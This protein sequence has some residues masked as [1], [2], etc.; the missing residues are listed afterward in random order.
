MAVGLV[1]IMVLFSIL[2]QIDAKS[3]ETETLG[4]SA[5]SGLAPRAIPVKPVSTIISASGFDGHV[6]F[7]LH[8]GLNVRQVAGRL[9][10]AQKG[11][12][13]AVNRIL[14]RSSVLAVR[15]LFSRSKD[16]LRAER[17]AAQ[18]ESRQ[19]LADLSLYYRLEVSNSDE[20]EQIIDRLN[21]DPDVEIAYYQPAPE[22]AEAPADPAE[23]PDFESDQD[24]LKPAPDGVD[25]YFAWT[26]IGGR[27]QD[28]KIV[29]IEGAW[30]TTHEDLTKSVGGLLGGTMINN[31]NW[32]NHGTAVIGEMIA[33][34]NGF[35][36]T[37][38]AYEA[39][40]GMVSIAS[41]SAAEAISLATDSL[42]PGDAILIELHA[43]GPRYDFE[44]RDDQLGY[45]CMEYWQATFDAIQISSAKG[46]IVCEAAGN[47]AED[48]DDVIYENRFDTTY[49]NSH[50]IIC[51]AGAPPSGTYGPDRSRLS[52]SNYGERVNLQGYG[53]GV[54]TT[55]YGSLY[56]SGGED[57]YYTS[58]F[59]GT[60]SASPIVTGAV[61]CLSGYY[62]AMF[63]AVITPDAARDVLVATGSS[64]YPDGSEH[65]GPRP[66]LYGAITAVVAPAPIQISPSYWDTA[67]TQG[68]EATKILTI[69]NDLVGTAWE[70]EAS[71]QEPV[72]FR[73]PDDSWLSVSPLSG[74]VPGDGGTFDLTI[75]VDAALLDPVDGLAKGN[76]IVQAPG[77]SPDYQLVIPVFVDT[78]C[79]DDETYSVADSDEPFGPV[80]DWI[81]AA[82]LGSAI[83]LVDYYNSH[84]PSAALDDGT[85]GPIPIGF[86]FD[87]YGTI[88]DELYIG[89]NGAVSFTETE[90]NSNGYF[91][92]ISIPGAFIDDGIFAF[93][94]DLAID[95]AFGHGDIF[96]YQS[97]TN[98][99][100]VIE[101][102]Q[103]GNFN[104]DLDTLTTFEIILTADGLICI[105][106][107]DVGT[108][109]LEQTATVGLQQTGCRYE[110]Y[111][112]G[113]VPADNTPHSSLTVQF[114]S[115]GCD[116]AVWGDVNGDAAI[117]PIDVVFMVN[118]VYLTSDMRV[119]PPNC[120]YEAGD[121]N[122]DGGVNPVDVVHFVNYVYMTITPFPCTDPCLP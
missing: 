2:S 122:C 24:Y 44:S 121:V 102:Y 20:A 25:A 73:S 12:L 34:N 104:D 85:A 1:A 28:V 31:S 4:V 97:P 60:S 74:T 57:Y 90:L 35:G 50:A 63:G 105:Q 94:N 13:A 16:D 80:F 87:F 5:L 21:R 40:I 36:V 120:P 39:E 32:R 89:V 110:P 92:G 72:L 86:G 43:P 67:V 111:V 49:R 70:F 33:D 112:D 58:T 71:A 22:P 51:G 109:G 116:C 81:D 83:P 15:R 41:M 14:S 11:D 103:V 30:R 37:G 61:A 7:K 68:E 99:I 76:I 77:G 46:I 117:N 78:W 84:N 79:P 98:D 115:S 29:D 107:L 106:F 82:S 96:V 101:W 114:G 69:T 91:S 53:R 27:G 64:Q 3:L 62:Q 88:Y 93:W 10:D 100:F 26:R 17:L 48:F 9:V 47:G 42:E 65:I 119:Q 55:G 45:V 95:P 52:F 66:D 8:E 108:S 113:A 118:H 59:S 38:I 6:V 56:S 23:T 75:T 19:Q 54:V 18:A